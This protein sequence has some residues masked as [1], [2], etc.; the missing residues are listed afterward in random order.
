MGANSYLTPPNS[1]GFAP[2]YD[3]IEAFIL[4]VE[5]K[6][7]WRLYKPRNENEYLA[8]YSSRNFTQS[9]IGEPILDTIV[10]AGDL[11]YFPR[12]TIHQGETMDSHSLHITLSVYQNNSWGDFLEKLLPGALNTA[13]ETDSEFRKGLPL[14]YLRYSGFVHSEN[15][16]KN[17]GEFKEKVK[18]LFNKLIDY[19]DI[20]NAADL[21]AKK[22]VHDFLPPVLLENEQECS[23]VQDGEQMTANGTVINRVEIEPDTRVRLLRSHCIR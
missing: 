21:M 7:R 6:K 10:N 20:D 17:K 2:H 4:Q 9:E 15:Q 19:I 14:D 5:G 22:H 23:I 16:S 1:Q 3:D 11:L 8:R 12:G 13:M 18:H